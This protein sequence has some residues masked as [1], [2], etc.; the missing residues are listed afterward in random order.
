MSE[1]SCT[2]DPD[3]YVYDVTTSSSGKE[4]VSLR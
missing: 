2:N 1:F 4:E 3:E